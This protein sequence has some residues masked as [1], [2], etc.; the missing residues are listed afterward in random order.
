MKS[1]KGPAI[2]KSFW[3]VRSPTSACF[4]AIDILRSGTRKDELLVDK[5][6]LSKMYVLRRILAPMGT[7]DAIEFLSDK[8]RSSK[9][10]ADFFESM[11]T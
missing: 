6:I 8:L 2:P 1:S 3:T 7:I 11:N 9:N 4:L 5:G 10:N